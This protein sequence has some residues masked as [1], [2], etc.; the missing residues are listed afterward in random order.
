MRWQFTKDLKWV[1]NLFQI[2]NQ[3]VSDVME[4]ES[5]VK[6]MMLTIANL[7]IFG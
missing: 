6:N 5:I 3:I 1:K 7:A 4:K 2:K